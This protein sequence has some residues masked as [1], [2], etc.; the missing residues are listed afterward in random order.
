V[1]ALRAT[2]TVDENYQIRQQVDRCRRL[3][4]MTVDDEMRRTLEQL[5]DEYESMLPKR[6]DSFM[7]GSAS[8]R[9]QQH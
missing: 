4:S 2:V 9:L 7:L 5:A 1:W 8:R 3:A 6:P